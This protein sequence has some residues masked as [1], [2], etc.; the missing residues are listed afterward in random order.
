MIG[1]VP[2]NS[3]VFVEFE[4]GGGVFEVAKLAVGAGGLDFAE[5]V[6]GAL[7]LAGEALALDAE[8]GEQAMGVDDVEGDFVI[9][10]E[11]SGGA[12]EDLGFEQRDAVEAPGGVGDFHDEL[13]FGGS[14]GLVLVEEAAAMGFEGGRVFR[15]EDG[16]GGGQAVAQGVER[17]TLLAGWGARAGGVLG[18][19]AVDG[20]AGTR[21][22]LLVAG[23]H[24][25]VSG[26]VLLRTDGIFGRRM[27]EVVGRGRDWVG[28]G[29]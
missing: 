6:E 22:W 14:G 12:R 3:S 28:G 1:R 10:R 7:E 26:A 4:E 24:A 25:M 2:G 5:G 11:G 29:G 19:G 16:G 18:V 8:V 13:R 20:G 21:G 9:G 17:R 15:G 27:A 23:C